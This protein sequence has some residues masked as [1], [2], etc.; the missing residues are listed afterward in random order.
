MTVSTRAPA[1]GRRAR[2]RR[3]AARLAA[4]AGAG[5][6]AAALA[7]ELPALTVKSDALAAAWGVRRRLGPG[8][9]R[10]IALTFDDGPHAQGTPAVLELLRAAGTHATFFLVGEQVA[11]RPALAAE[12][13][14]AG[15]EIALH[16]DR[17]RNLMRLTPGQVRDDLVRATDR[18]AAATDRVPVLYR[19]PYGLLTAP[20]VRFARAQR[21]RAAA[22]ERPRPRLVADRDAALDRAA[23]APRAR[24]RGGR[25]APRRRR[26]QRA[27]LVAHDRGRA[28]GDPG[29][30]RR[31]RPGRSDGARR[32]P[33][34]EL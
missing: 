8:A 29:R 18:I 4:A 16:C 28:A 25:A 15:H 12:I 20:A 22:V 30:A 2:R 19:P 21:A 7:Y 23:R 1:A 17:H 24:P 27:G 26:L 6:G 9:G 5:A 32:R 3:V 10:G 31:A 13:A 14:A 33:A 11:R 34:G